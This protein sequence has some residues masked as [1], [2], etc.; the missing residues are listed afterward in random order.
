MRGFRF[1]ITITTE[2]D[3]LALLPN[4][5]QERTKREQVT[6]SISAKKKKKKWKLS[7]APCP[8]ASFKRTDRSVTKPKPLSV[9]TIPKP[10]TQSLSNAAKLNPLHAWMC[11][12]YFSDDGS[13]LLDAFLYEDAII[14]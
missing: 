2:A 14:V 8:K 11:S 10:S 12:P 4:G 13:H 6:D 1:A 7:Q 3:C 9:A 5:F